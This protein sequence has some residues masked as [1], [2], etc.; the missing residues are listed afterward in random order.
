[1]RELFVLGI[2]RSTPLYVEIA[3][4]A[5]WSIKGFFHYNDERTGQIDHG[6]EIKGSFDDLFKQNIKGMNFLLTM[7]DMGIREK[8]SE[9]IIQLGGTIPSII[10]PSAQISRF[11]NIADTGVIIGRNVEV[12]NDVTIHE[13]TIIRSSVIVCHG[14]TIG[15]DVFIG[16]KAL[17]GAYIS[18]DS[19][20][21]IGQG[22]ILVSGKTE[23]IGRNTLVG[24]GALVT[25]PLPDNVV[26]VGSPARIIKH[27]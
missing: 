21:F 27:K 26:A 1:M 14:T 23:H 18:I 5:G 19:L 8:V 6:F 17:V 20:A 16:P 15:S 10:H 12:Q 11:A 13:N 7:G 25:K 24:A 22:S 4:A 2:G 9:N 3:E